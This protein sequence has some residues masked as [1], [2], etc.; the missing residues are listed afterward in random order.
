M[1]RLVQ[2]LPED[3]T[4]LV[5]VYAGTRAE[6]MRNWG[7]SEQENEKFVSMQYRFQVQAY[8]MKYP[9]ADWYVIL[10][11]KQQ[12]GRLIVARTDDAIVLVDISLLPSFRN[13]GI[14]TFYL[15]SLQRESEACLRPVVLRVLVS[16]R[17][18]LLYERLGFCITQQSDLLY[19]MEWHL[20]YMQN[21]N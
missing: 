12:A 2:A 6:E 10:M 8:R 13:Q 14:G 21:L 9:E 4:F 19:N 5:Q 7:W 17:A 11:N 1:L 18:R 15:K 3:E 20:S 16:N